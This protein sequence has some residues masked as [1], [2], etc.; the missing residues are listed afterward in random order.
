MYFLGT[1]SITYSFYRFYKIRG[2][3]AILNPG[4]EDHHIRQEVHTIIAVIAVDA[5]WSAVLT[6]NQRQMK[7]RQRSLNLWKRFDLAWNP[8]H[9]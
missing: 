7:P 2:A 8:G 3:H 4:V 9:W 5:T 6:Y 1:P